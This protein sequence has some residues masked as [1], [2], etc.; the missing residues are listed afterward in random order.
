MYHLSA[1]SF[2]LYQPLTFWCCYFCLITVAITGMLFKASTKA[3]KKR[4]SAGPSGSNKRAKGTTSQPIR[5]SSPSP[6]PPPPTN[7][8]QALVSASQAPTFKAR[9]W[10][11]CAEDSIVAPPEGSKHVSDNMMIMVMQ[12]DD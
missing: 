9:V 10:E 7:A 6:P 2:I 8:L 12:L 5:V 1:G 11:S 4:A 3:T